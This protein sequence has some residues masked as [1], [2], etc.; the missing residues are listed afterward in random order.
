MLGTGRGQRSAVYDQGFQVLQLLRGEDRQVGEGPQ[1]RLGNRG[2]DPQ[3]AEKVDVPGVDLHGQRR[4]LQAAAQRV[5]YLHGGMYDAAVPMEKGHGMKKLPPFAFGYRSRGR[6]F[7][8]R[9]VFVF[10]RIYTV[11]VFALNA[12]RLLAAHN[13]YPRVRHETAL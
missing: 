7:V 6:V 8:C 11:F 2:P 13:S 12:L 5:S 4:H 9:Y 1:R 10:M 3:R